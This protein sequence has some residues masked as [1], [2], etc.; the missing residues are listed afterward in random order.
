MKIVKGTVPFGAFKT[1]YR[2]TGDPAAGGTALV[3]VHGGPGSTH[4]YLLNLTALADHGIRVVHY[5]QLGNG[6][7]SHLP[8]RPKEFWT[9]Q[10]FLDELDN[11]LRQLGIADDYVLFG[12]SWGGML[13]AAHASARPAGLR[14]LIIANAPASYP[15]WI[16]ELDRLRAE[17]PEGV[18]ETLRR[19]EAAGTTDSAEYYA[20]ARVF[21]DRHLC[22]LTP[23]PRDYQA[24]FYELYNDPTVYFAMNGPTEFHLTGTLRNWSVVD[25]LGGIA[26]PTL[27]LAGRHDEVT[28]EAMR[29]FRERIPDVRPEVFEASSH[30]PHLEEPDRFRAVVADFLATRVGGEVAQR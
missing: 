25:L 30:V 26:V 6:G 1:W 27:V 11:L 4:D 19:H 8:D 7:S 10:L 28:D 9:V 24:S 20:A 5:D 23:W 3:T 18:D 13:A 2:I 15:L 17:L 29:P 22:R 21:Y 12:H 16:P 14:G